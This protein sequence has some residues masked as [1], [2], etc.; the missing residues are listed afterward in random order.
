MRNRSSPASVNPRRRFQFARQAASRA[1]DS[2]LVPT[3]FVALVFA[4]ATAAGGSN[5]ILVLTRSRRRRPRIRASPSRSS[6]VRRCATADRESWSR[7][8]RTVEPPL[9]RAAPGALPR[10][11]QVV[12]QKLTRPPTAPRLSPDPVASAQ[13]L[14]NVRR[15]RRTGPDEAQLHAG[16]L[17]YPV[18]L[19]SLT[20]T[21]LAGPGRFLR[22]VTVK[23]PC[24]TRFSTVPGLSKRCPPALR[25]ALRVVSSPP[26]SGPD[27]RRYFGEGSHLQR[28]PQRAPRRRIRRLD[29]T[30][31][32]RNRWA[33]FP[34][35]MM[36]DS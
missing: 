7:K 35:R 6:R 23:S 29:V 30:R 5:F 10:P 19:G 13:S 1:S 21:V 2:I 15:R 33:E 16:R 20:R 18:H 24:V 25:S 36:R 8:R 27:R 17:D 14:R 3:S 31:V 9:Q 34:H 12:C 22:L 32:C 26:G 28:F 4:T 11:G